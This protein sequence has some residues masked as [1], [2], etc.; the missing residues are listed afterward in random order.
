VQKFLK[1]VGFEDKDKEND[2]MSKD[3]DEGKD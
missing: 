1:Y 2:L 3:E